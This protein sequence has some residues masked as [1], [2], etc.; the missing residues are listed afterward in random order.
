[1]QIAVN[2][3]EAEIVRIVGAA[4]FAGADVLNME[5]GKGRVVLMQTAVFT[6]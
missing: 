4:V 6:A 3:C 5:R 1:M 2:A